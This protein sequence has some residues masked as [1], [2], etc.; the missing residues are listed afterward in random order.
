MPI[1]IGVSQDGVKKGSNRV[2][3]FIGTGVTVTSRDD[4]GVNVDVQTGTPA[5]NVETVA[6]GDGLSNSGTASD[7]IL[8][9]NAGNGLTIASDLL[10]PSYGTS[11]NTVCEGDD[12]RLPTQ[13]ENDALVGTSGTP[14]SSN[15]Y[16]T[17]S[18]SRNDDSRAPTGAAGGDLA[19]TYPNPT[20]DGLQGRAVASTAPSDGEAL[21]W[22]NSLS[23]WEPGGVPGSGVAT[24]TAGAGLNN[25]GTAADPVLDVNV[26]NGLQVTGDNVQPVYGSSANTVCEGNDSRLSDARTPTAHK[27]T[28]E[29]GGSDVI[30]GNIDANARVEV[31]LDGTPVGKRRE[32]NFEQGTDITISV[33]EDVT[34]ERMDVRVSS[35]ST[36]AGVPEFFVSP[37]QDALAFFGLHSNSSLKTVDASPNGLNDQ[38]LYV[39]PIRFTADMVLEA[40][41]WQPLQAAA[42]NAD[43][44]K[45]GLF[46]STG[47]KV[48]ETTNAVDASGDGTNR[49]LK[50]VLEA[51]LSISFP[52]TIT[53]G[54]Y[55]LGFTNAGSTDADNQYATFYWDDTGSPNLIPRYGTIT[56]PPG[57][58]IPSSINPTLITDANGSSDPFCIAMFFY[59]LD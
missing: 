8:D 41:Y 46:D 11:A 15:K 9:I 17:D 13:G 53:Y 22:N 10:Q 5:N 52:F 25:S 50:E 39:C 57:G 40:I 59:G 23:R 12:S 45:F 56:I 38:R 47:T 19:G 31:S 54:Q 58:A 24:V 27:T 14:S 26:A 43:V 36:T 29:T 3:N 2:I 20:V 28:H 35:S 55:Y 18:D 30:D 44:L 51:D 1:L 34:N 49:P 32:I 6:A 37:L 42:G 4:G 21:V 33:T 48:L 16:V 7:P